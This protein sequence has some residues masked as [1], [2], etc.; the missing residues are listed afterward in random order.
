[1]TTHYWLHDASAFK[2]RCDGQSMKHFV[3]YDKHIPDHN[4]GLATET[5]R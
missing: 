3:Y 1:M 2:S 5:N 4:M